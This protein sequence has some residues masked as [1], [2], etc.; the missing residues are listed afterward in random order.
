MT[1]KYEVVDNG[2]KYLVGEFIVDQKDA[3]KI[4]DRLLRELG[5]VEVIISK[6]AGQ[7]EGPYKWYMTVS[8]KNFRDMPYGYLKRK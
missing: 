5:C 8:R 2:T 1:Y 6:R 7:L 4:A 3:E